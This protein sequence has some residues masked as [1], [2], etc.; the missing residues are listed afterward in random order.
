MKRGNFL[1]DLGH[2]FV[3]VFQFLQ[4]G[5]VFVML[6]PAVAGFEPDGEGFGEVFGGVGLGVPHVQVED[7]TFGVGF[8]GVDLGVFHGLW[9]EDFAVAFAAMEAIGGVESVAGFVAKDAQA[10]GFGAAFDF[11]HLALFQFF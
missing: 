5:P 9:A 2:E 8:W 11:E 4:R 6:S 3:D 7:V 1:A 10:G